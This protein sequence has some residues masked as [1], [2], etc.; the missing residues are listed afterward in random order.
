MST[1]DALRGGTR[2]GQL[3]HLRQAEASERPS[4]LQLSARHVARSAIERRNVVVDGRC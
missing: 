1:E 2:P 3:P 4:D